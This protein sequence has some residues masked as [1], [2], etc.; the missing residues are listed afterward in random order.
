MKVA[1]IG[2][3]G[4][5]GQNLVNELAERCHEVLAIARNTEK[6]IQRENVVAKSVDVTDEQALAAAVNGY[7]VVVS[8]FNAGWTNPNIY[9]DFMK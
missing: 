3:T 2:A 9:N 8:A 1:V 6:V 7:D 4:F 5:V